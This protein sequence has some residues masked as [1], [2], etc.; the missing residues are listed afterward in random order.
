MTYKEES[1]FKS[2]PLKVNKLQISKEIFKK[3]KRYQ[4]NY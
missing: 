3:N 4:K 2:L 1:S